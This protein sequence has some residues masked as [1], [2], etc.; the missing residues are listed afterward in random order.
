MGARCTGVLTAEV[1][2]VAGSGATECGGEIAAAESAGCGGSTALTSGA[3]SGA[4]TAPW[5]GRET[6]LGTA[7]ATTCGAVATPGAPVVTGPSVLPV[8][9]TSTPMPMPT[10]ANAARAAIQTAG[11]V[12]LLLGAGVCVMGAPVC[13]EAAGVSAGDG[14]VAANGLFGPGVSGLRAGNEPR[15]SCSP[16]FGVSGAVS[17][18]TVASERPSSAAL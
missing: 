11:F 13:A 14:V 2:A 8:P 5:F 6:A 7:S 16:E 17:P 10:T 18:H 3:G 15:A 12:A 1:V 4:R 9:L